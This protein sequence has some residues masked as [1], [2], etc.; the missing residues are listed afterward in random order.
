M[1]GPELQ[2][3]LLPGVAEGDKLHP[4]RRGGLLDEGLAAA[5]A[6]D[7]DPDGLWMAH[8]RAPELL[9]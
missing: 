7:A 9:Y 1:G 8:F 4:D 2:Q 5:Q 3:S 6:D